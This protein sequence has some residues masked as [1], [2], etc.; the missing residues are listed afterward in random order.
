MNKRL[1]V[2][3]IAAFSPA[4]CVIMGNWWIIESPVQATETGSWPG[5]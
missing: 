2:K 3:I 1:Y 4:C 5:P